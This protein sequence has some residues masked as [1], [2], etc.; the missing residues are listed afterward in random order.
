MLNGSGSGGAQD[1]LVYFAL[2]R[3]VHF[4]GGR[5]K[6]ANPVVVNIY[7]NTLNQDIT[8]HGVSLGQMDSASGH[9][10]AKIG[11]GCHAASFV[12]CLFEWVGTI[13]DA[14]GLDVVQAYAGESCSA[15]RV[16]GCKFFIGDGG[17]VTACIRIAPT[18]NRARA[19]V[20]MGNSFGKL[21]NAGSAT[22]YTD[23]ILLDQ[24]TEQT[25]IAGNSFTAD[26]NVTFTA[27]IR[28]ASAN[29][30]GT[31]IMTN[32]YDGFGTFTAKVVNS[33]AA[34]VTT[35]NDPSAADG[36]VV[37]NTAVLLDAAPTVSANQL[38]LG[39]TTATTIGAAGG[40]AALPAT[41]LGYLIFNLGGTSIKVPYYN[42]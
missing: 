22:T 41:P 40:A 20:I 10:I 23:A 42:A 35:L 25:I 30:L 28:I 17:T 6:N 26:N 21:G 27:C 39:R 11:T 13:T 32:A 24:R 37:T 3:G 5:L 18:S 15:T 7:D 38:G 33:A 31:T 19:T 14:I 16:E 9:T 4:F 34:K 2:S 36:Q 29:V 8:F 12:D 1:G